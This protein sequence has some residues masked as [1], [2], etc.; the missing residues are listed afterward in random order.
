MTEFL[1]D[2][3][4]SMGMGEH[5]VTNVT[6][7]AIN[8]SLDQKIRS[9]GHVMHYSDRQPCRNCNR[10]GAKRC[11]RCMNCP[12]CVQ[13]GQCNPS[14]M[15]PGA[16]KPASVLSVSDRNAQVLGSAM[17]QAIYK[18]FKMQDFHSVFSLVQNGMDVNFQ[19]IESDR[20]TA[21]MAAAHHGRE[22]AVNKLLSLGA[23]PALVDVNGDAA[24]TFA[25]RHGHMELMER[26]K[27]AAEEG[28]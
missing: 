22:D 4:E 20:S 5:F 16:P 25:K 28:K 8:A 1:D 17:D 13:K 11:E 26:L 15:T 10:M 12:K 9:L 18:A 2:D 14:T 6:Q 3:E 19:R 21:L 23:N 7:T 27:R 24:W